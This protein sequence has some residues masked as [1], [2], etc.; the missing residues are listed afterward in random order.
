[1]ELRLRVRPQPDRARLAKG[2]LAG[3]LLVDIGLNPDGG[4]VDQRE[5]RIARLHHRT[6]LRVAGD[7]QRIIRRDQPV[8][9]EKGF[10]LSQGRRRVQALRLDHC[11]IGFRSRQIGAR[12]VL[13]ALGF[14]GALGRSDVALHQPLLTTVRRLALGEHRAGAHDCGIGLGE[15]GLIGRHCRMGARHP[16][17]LLGRVKDG[18]LLSPDHAV[19]GIGGKRGQGCT[20]LEADTAENPRLDGAKS[21]NAKGHIAFRLNDRHRQ[22]PFGEE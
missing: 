4:R 14:L 12:H 17:L 10:L 13:I 15:I 18:Q 21:V 1:V 16:R 7:D 11:Q 6:R 5:D 19:P 20:H 9:G 3:A 22:R 2:K 8:M